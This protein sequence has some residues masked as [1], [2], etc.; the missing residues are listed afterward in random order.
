MKWI[1]QER[2]DDTYNKQHVHNKRV[3]RSWQTRGMRK[4]GKKYILS[5]WLK[6]W[7]KVILSCLSNCKT[8]FAPLSSEIYFGSKIHHVGSVF[9]LFPN[10]YRNCQVTGCLPVICQLGRVIWFNL[11]FVCAN[12]HKVMWKALSNKNLFSRG[13]RWD[14]KVLTNGHTAKAVVV[15]LRDFSEFYQ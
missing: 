11:A 9:N 15:K 5:W 12:Y 4:N 8:C 13:S 14:Y 1:Y 10:L 6:T 7:F 3:A 2:D